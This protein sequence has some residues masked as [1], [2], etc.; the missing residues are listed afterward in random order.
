MPQITWED[1]ILGSPVRYGL[2]AYS[3]RPAAADMGRRSSGFHPASC[4]KSE[5][6]ALPQSTRVHPSER[7]YLLK[8]ELHYE[9]VASVRTG[10]RRSI[11]AMDGMIEM[12]PNKIDTRVIS[13]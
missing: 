4:L 12:T 5:E 6:P 11:P 8:F 3:L 2:S 7:V 10:R 1:P 9:D 13:P